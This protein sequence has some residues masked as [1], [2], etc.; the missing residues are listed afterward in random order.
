[1]INAEKL[2]HLV[3]KKAKEHNLDV[4]LVYRNY[5]FEKL[6]ERLYISKHKDDFIL[7][8]GYLIG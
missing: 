5:M 1:M 2:N 7:K 4:E 8:G 6:L 3:R